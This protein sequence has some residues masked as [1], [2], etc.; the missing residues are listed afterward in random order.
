MTKSPSPAA[1]LMLVVPCY[2]EAR[3]IDVDAFTS[4]LHIMPSLH[5]CFVDDGST[6]DTAAMIQRLAERMPDRVTLR[7]LGQNRG[8]AEAVRTGLQYACDAATSE[9]AL[10]GFWD[11]DLS[12]ALTELPALQAVFGQWPAVQWVWG[13]RLKALGRDITRGAL[14]HYLGRGFATVT[15]VLTG[16]EAYDTQCGAKLFRVTPLLREVLSEPFLSRWVFDVEL[17]TRADALLQSSS[18]SSPGVEHLV[19]EQPLQRWHH[20]EGSKVRAWDFARAVA[21]LWVIRRARK[22]WEQRAR[23]AGSGVPSTE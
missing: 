3:R 12:A 13:I 6:D 10:C 8:K 2:N 15:S 21:E 18:P 16:V 1:A 23:R 9:A 20:R 11:A 19:Y 22:R 5:L 14:R 7:R 4:A 17:L